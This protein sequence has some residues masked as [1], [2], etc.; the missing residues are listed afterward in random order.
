MNK[1]T[2][3]IILALIVV[4]IGIYVLMPKQTGP[5]P[6]T[7]APEKIQYV[8]SQYGFKFELPIAWQNYSIATSTW[9]GLAI[10]DKGQTPTEHGPIISI[11]NP[12]WT[13]STPYQDIPIMVFTSEQWEALQQDEFHI[14]AAPV[15][16]SELGRN[17]EYVFALP[18]RYNYA[19]PIG[20]Q[21]VEEILSSKP[22]QAL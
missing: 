19:F 18:A 1:K 2:L 8:N 20:Y 21:E 7:T 22:L 14:G 17:A 11:R 4:A 13:L 15:N 16:P 6:G 9:E 5:N 10:S 3:S 12:K